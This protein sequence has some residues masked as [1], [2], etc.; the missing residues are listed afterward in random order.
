MV[1]KGQHDPGLAGRLIVVAA[2]L[3]F[4]G[5]GLNAT[6][7]QSPT[8]DEPAHTLRGYVLQLTGGLQYQTGH[9]PASHRLIGL[10]LP[11][12][13]TLPTPDELPS[14]PGGE[15][16]QLASE[17]LWD[18]GVDISRLL[19]LA[20]LPILWTGLI[21][22]SLVAS[23]ALSW[24]GRNAMTVAMVLFAAAPNV[25]ASATLAT[26]DF[27][28]AVSYFGTVYA[29]WRYWRHPC[30]RW[31]LLTAV[32]LG[33]ALA[34][35]LTAVLLL[36]VLFLLTFLFLGKDRP[37]W[38]PFLAWLGLLPVAA[39]ILWLIYG[40]Q[41]DLV[42]GWPWPVPAAAYLG[43]WQ[44]VLDHVER[45]HRA[46]F[47]GELSGDGWWSYFPVTFAVKTPLLT[48]VLLVIGLIVIM[49]RRSLWST[50]VFLLVPV[51]VL[52][53]AAMTSRLNIGYRHI[54]PV[55]PF[56]FVIA[57]TAVLWIR[58]WAVT[59]LL[60]VLGL[61]WYVF[62]ALRQQPHFLAY[63]NEV[64][65]G[66]AQG[67]RYLGDS[68]LDWGQDLGRL[69]ALV[70]RQGGTWTISYAGTG[71]PAY[72]GIRPEQLL[73]T[74]AGERPFAA[75][76]PPPGYYAISANHWQGI[77]ED[78]DR[79]DW[80][81]RQEIVQSLGGSILIYTVNQQAIGT[82]VAH[83]VDPAPLLEPSAAEA[84][85]GQTGLRHVWFDCR[86]SW[87]LPGGDEPGWYIT[88]QQDDWWIMNQ[89]AP[90]AQDNL[91]LVYRHR[92][93]VET[94]S[95]D[96]YYWP[97]GALLPDTQRILRE[98]R[99]TEGLAVEL[100]HAPNEL[101]TLTGYAVQDLVWTGYWQIVSSTPQPVSIRAHLYATSGA[102]P[103]VADSLGYAAEQWRA[104]DTLWQRYQFA[105]SE[106]AAYLETGF[107][108][109]QTLDLIGSLLHLPAPP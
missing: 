25:L 54:L 22:G 64:A 24:H 108:N 23:W 95:Y 93:T 15:R 60:L 98:A 43:S 77:L 52:F 66:T 7:T 28:T 61:C 19:F 34:S 86:Q 76:N 88:P 41:I 101:A 44:N 74:A 57:S 48:L 90:E 100:P 80:F 92:A 70:K 4:F 9:T 84:V 40:L 82:W 13:R 103:Q 18:S 5:L 71:D 46:F 53:A 37:W 106:G 20:R 63:F 109:Y 32:F 107:Y 6:L 21:L 69:A 68:N 35:K 26:T 16:L 85:L 75:A 45:G 72:Y 81:R 99:T 49:A 42:A 36:P 62:A 55:L 47:L 91:Q 73:D 94:P 3:L 14:W 39:I 31:W 83:C 12:E 102:A 27:L 104:G 79:F 78:A 87:V 38:Q 96:V 65:G 67:Y 29:W 1:E 2:L 8:N 17:L 50:A 58:R 97:G 51:A 59:R 33:I 10:L 105:T 11:T 30:K 89:L 56:V